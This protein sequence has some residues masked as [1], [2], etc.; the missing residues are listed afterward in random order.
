M[1]GCRVESKVWPK[2]CKFF[3]K[4]LQKFGKFGQKFGVKP[5]FLAS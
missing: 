1:V 2:I 5:V 4:N 3:A